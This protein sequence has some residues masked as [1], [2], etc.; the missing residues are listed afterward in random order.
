MLSLNSQTDQSMQESRE[1]VSILTKEGNGTVGPFSNETLLKNL[2]L[3]DSRKA[4][5]PSGNVQVQVRICLSETMTFNSI[6]TISS[7]TNASNQSAL[8]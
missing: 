8:E 5:S 4:Q 7:K 6:R 3:T 1:E 2:T